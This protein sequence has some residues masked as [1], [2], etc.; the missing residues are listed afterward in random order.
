MKVI[1][2]SDTKYQWMIDLGGSVHGLLG[3]TLFAFAAGHI[4]M[5]LYHYFGKDKSIMKRMI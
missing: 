4:I 1:E 3:W 2:A 5:A